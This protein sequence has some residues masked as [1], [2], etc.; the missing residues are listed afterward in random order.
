MCG[1]D[2]CHN[3]D[4]QYEHR[5][6]PY[7]EFVQ[8]P[9]PRAFLKDAAGLPTNPRLLIAQLHRDGHLSVKDDKLHL[10]WRE[11]AHGS[12]DRCSRVH[13]TPAAAK[14]VRY[15][16]GSLAEGPKS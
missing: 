16:I 7:I 13:L 8:V 1:G 14:R 9:I 15:V 4:C 2:P 3:G 12:G 10:N 11:K 5:A 6:V